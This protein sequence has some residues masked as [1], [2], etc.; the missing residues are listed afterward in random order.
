MRARS[1]DNLLPV[2]VIVSTQVNNTVFQR[3]RDQ[4]LHLMLGVLKGD[5]STFGFFSEV[6]GYD[7]AGFFQ[8]NSSDIRKRFDAIIKQLLSP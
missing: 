8:R 2:I 4:R 7:L 6:I 1:D 5:N 3:Y